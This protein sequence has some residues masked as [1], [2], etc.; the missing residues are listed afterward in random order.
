[1]RICFV[2]L[3]NICRSPAAAA[4]FARL[5]EEAALAVTVDSAGTGPYHLGERP[6]E[7]TRAEAHRRGITVE[8]PARRFTADDFAR[9]DL[10]VAMDRA[11]ER[12]LR[13]LAP[14]K[15]AQAKIVLLRSFDPDTPDD[16]APDVPD[17]FGRPR[18]VYADMFDL[19]DPACRGLLDHVA[20]RTARQ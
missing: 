1:V 2:C 5:A 20:E 13:R 3:G 15:A 18:S 8:H 19:L 6:H 7:H 16:D 17:P 10:V 12:A 11:N 14:D 9:F 4:V